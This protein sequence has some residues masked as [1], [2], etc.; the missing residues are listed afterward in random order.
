MVNGNTLQTEKTKYRL[1]NKL[2]NLTVVEIQASTFAKFRKLF[3]STIYKNK[4]T[5]HLIAIIPQ[6]DRNRPVTFNTATELIGHKH[7]G[8]FFYD[9]VKLKVIIFE[10]FLTPLFFFDELIFPYSLYRDISHR[11]LAPQVLTYFII[12]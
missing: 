7:K 8:I 11:N 5:G 3:Q 6:R 12:I 4:L 10:S 9:R 2:E 1:F